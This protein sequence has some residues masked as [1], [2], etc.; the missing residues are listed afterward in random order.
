MSPALNKYIILIA[1][2]VASA[3]LVFFPS[4]LSNAAAKI[5]VLMIVGASCYSN[6]FGRKPR[7]ALRYS[8]VIALALGILL[9]DFSRNTLQTIGE[10]F[11]LYCLIVSCILIGCESGSKSSISLKVVGAICIGFA[12]TRLLILL[13]N[14]E[15]EREGSY[16]SYLC[17]VSLF[18][19]VGLA[20]LDVSEYKF[21]LVMLLLFVLVAYIG[22][23]T[24]AIGIFYFLIL[25][26]L[27]SKFRSEGGKI[28]YIFFFI[29]TVMATTLLVAYLNVLVDG[30]AKIT[31]IVRYDNISNI[32]V[33]SKNYDNRSNIWNA[34]IPI[35]S[36]N[37][38]FGAG[39]SLPSYVSDPDLSAHNLTLEILYR[40]GILGLCIYGLLLII[41]YR[42]FLATIHICKVRRAAQLLLVGLVINS[43]GV[44]TFY[45]VLN[46]AEY[47]YWGYLSFCL[48]CSLKEMHLNK[49]IHNWNRLN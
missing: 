17:F 46:W 16:L 43:F 2:S 44:F 13:N 20:L 40:R 35:I 10:W 18:I 30:I 4:T 42:I 45:S 22:A 27:G 36:E 48:G 28:A 41:M 5:V 7:S 31:Q 3:V 33:F 24:L 39:A 1:M 38:Y 15:V 25:Q 6:F 34:L 19:Y 8:V 23:R 11:T 26:I 12:I 9:I 21:N 37:I 32:Y 29:L 14:I 49:F 47:L